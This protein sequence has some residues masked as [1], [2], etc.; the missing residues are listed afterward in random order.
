KLVPVAILL[1]VAVVLSRFFTEPFRFTIQADDFLFLNQLKNKSA[2]DT[3]LAILHSSNGRWFSHFYTA[4]VFTVLKTNWSIYFIYDI[5]AFLLLVLSLFCFFN[6]FI[7]KGIISQL[8]FLKQI[9]L[10]FF[11]ACVFFIFLMDGRYEVFYWVSSISNHLL[12]VIF[13]FF[14]LSL[15]IGKNVLRLPLLAVLAFCLGQMN[16]I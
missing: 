8:T 1:I 16:E 15:F 13:F 7:K 6:S 5:F 12:S 10:A 3:S 11:T 4:L 9:L 2:W 14:A